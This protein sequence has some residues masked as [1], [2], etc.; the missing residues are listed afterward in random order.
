[1]H[2]TDQGQWL[3]TTKKLPKLVGEIQRRESLQEGPKET[4]T[5]VAPYVSIVRG[6]IYMVHEEEAI[7]DMRPL[8]FKNVGLSESEK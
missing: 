5:G 3:I 2:W 7:E 1:M 8:Y 6:S 4:K